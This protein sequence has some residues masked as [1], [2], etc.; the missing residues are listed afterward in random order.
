MSPD[1]WWGVVTATGA[2]M[3]TGA[4]IVVTFA[5]MVGRESSGG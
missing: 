1:F 3:G 2:W 4:M 5:W